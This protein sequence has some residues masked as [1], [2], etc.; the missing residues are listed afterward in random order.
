MA[1][2]LSRPQWVNAVHPCS[3]VPPTW[4]PSVEIRWS[5]FR[6]ISTMGFAILVRSCHWD[7]IFILNQVL[8]YF[9]YNVHWVNSSSPGAA[10][11]R[12]WTGL[13]LFQVMTCHLSGTKP[14]LEPM[15]QNCQLDTLGQTSVK[16]E[17]EY[18]TYHSWK[19]V[20]NCCLQNGSHF[21]RGRVNSPVIM[22]A[23]TL[24]TE[25]DSAV[26]SQA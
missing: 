16:F 10:Y 14:L 26:W 18:K 5:Y 25:T 20:S 3:R 8:S 15:L 17:S 12:W 9:V 11:M 21:V 23:C 4:I 13:A 1:A 2:I 19:C 24:W 6:H 22:S 7:D